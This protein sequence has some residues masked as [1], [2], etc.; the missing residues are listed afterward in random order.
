ML[1]TRTWEG[2]ARGTTLAADGSVTGQWLDLQ[3][4][5][6]SLSLFLRDQNG[7]STS[8]DIDYEIG[9]FPSGFT[10]SIGGN[11]ELSAQLLN[12]LPTDA[13]TCGVNLDCDAAAAYNNI[14]H[15]ALTLPDGRY[16]RFIVTNDSG[17]AD[18]KVDLII[19]GQI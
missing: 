18:A 17:M 5:Q 2:I 3:N 19:E 10:P 8:I 14:V 11:A 6:G 13:G 7:A 9:V 15:K 12:V 16:F 1:H 4:V